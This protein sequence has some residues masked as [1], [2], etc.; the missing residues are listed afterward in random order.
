MN[1]LVSK[2]NKTKFPAFLRQSGDGYTMRGALMA[3][4]VS[5]A[6]ADMCNDVNEVHYNPKAHGIRLLHPCY[7]VA[8]TLSHFT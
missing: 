8:L 1:T 2:E 7:A 6:L 5:S 3:L 4:Y